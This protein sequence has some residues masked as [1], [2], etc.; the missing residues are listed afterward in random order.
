MSKSP[1]Y[2]LYLFRYF[3]LLCS[4]HKIIFGLIFILPNIRFYFFNDIRFFTIDK[5]SSRLEK[6]AVTSMVLPK[7]VAYGNVLDMA[8]GMVVDMAVDS[9]MGP[10]ATSASWLVA[11]DNHMAVP[12]PAFADIQ[13]S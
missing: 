2:N 5:A 12:F 3:Y 9:N 1:M 6:N 8:L 13:G 10:F 11:H 7:N 4:F